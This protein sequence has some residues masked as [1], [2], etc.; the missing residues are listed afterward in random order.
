MPKKRT[1]TETW[2]K[3]IRP[4]IWK[5]DNGKCVNCGIKIGLKDSHIDHIISGLYG[6]NKLK[7]LRTLCARCHA[8]RLDIN[9]RGMIQSAIRKKLISADWRK[10]VWEE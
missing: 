9:H 7:N 8:L 6:D 10:F 4:I 5:R 2:Y 3:N 1:P